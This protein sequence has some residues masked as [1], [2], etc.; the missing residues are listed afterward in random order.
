M[1]KLI[2]EKLSKS[3]D[4]NVLFENLTISLNAGDYVMVHGDNGAGKT[5]LLK[6]IAGLIKQDQGTLTFLQCSRKKIGYQTANLDSFYSRL[7]AHD[8]LIYY[9]GL[10]GFSYKD[11]KELIF[12]YFKYTQ[13]DKKILN[14][15]FFNLSSGQK[16]LLSFIRAVIIKPEIILFDEPYTF[17]DKNTKLIVKDMIL[18]DHNESIKIMVNH[19]ANYEANKNKSIILGNYSS[20]IS[21]EM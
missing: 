3:F 19:D 13:L 18:N 12:N 20:N 5:T 6:I 9:L 15:K 10:K 2:I 14:Q 7:S 17:L 4:K 8:N 11:S 16:K 21:G 1:P